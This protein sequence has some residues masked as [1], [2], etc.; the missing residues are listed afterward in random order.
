[1]VL[2][3]ENS[4][5]LNRKLHLLANYA[6]IL[7]VCGGIFMIVF[8]LVADRVG[9]DPNDGWG[10]NRI[11][12]LETGYLL[13]V[14]AITLR[15][16]QARTAWVFSWTIIACIGQCLLVYYWYETAGTMKFIDTT[17]YYA[18]LARSFSHGRLDLPVLPDPRLL[19]LPDPYDPIQNHAYSIY[20]AALYNGKY[21]LSWMPFPGISKQ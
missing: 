11:L 8:A 15:L 5:I 3:P 18:M 19:S 14:I 9:I 7:L 13:S 12:V 16:R 6:P 17:Y 21:Y 20:D 2:K 1:M 4:A 10:V